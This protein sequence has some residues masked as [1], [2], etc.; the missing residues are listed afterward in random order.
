M[1]KGRQ[2]RKGHKILRTEFSYLGKV[3]FVFFVL[4]ALC[5]KAQAQDT[6]NYLNKAW[7]DSVANYR[8]RV[9]AY[10]QELY[11]YDWGMT[12]GMVP[13][14]GEAYVGKTG[15]GIGFSLARTAAVALSAVGLVRF[16]GGKSNF[17]VNLGMVAA[18]IFGY[19]GLKLWELADIRRTVSQKNEALVEEYGIATPDIM[20]HS[21]RYPTKTWPDWITSWP[22]ARHPQMFREA[23]NEP[24]PKVPDATGN[25]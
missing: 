4:S 9:E 23:V 6:A 19:I 21:I 7:R 10:H 3:L 11:S 17:A 15:T 22:P 24:L 5:P 16:I 18:G 25:K 20:P 12:F 14:A 13:V 2:G 8:G 1:L